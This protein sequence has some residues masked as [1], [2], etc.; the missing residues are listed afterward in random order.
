MFSNNGNSII[1]GKSGTSGNQQFGSWDSELGCSRFSGDYKPPECEFSDVDLKSET[2]NRLGEK[3]MFSEGSQMF[4]CYGP[5]KCEFQ[6][7]S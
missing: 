7:C 1:L 3:Y 5:K 2:Q 4:G 6:T